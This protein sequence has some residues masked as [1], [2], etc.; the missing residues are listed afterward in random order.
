MSDVYGK[1]NLPLQARQDFLAAIFYPFFEQ[2]GAEITCIARKSSNAEHIPIKGTAYADLAS[3]KGL[4]GSLK[5][6]G[7]PDSHGCPCFWLRIPGLSCRER[8][9]RKANRACGR[10]LEKS[11]PCFKPG[12]SRA[13]RATLP[14]V[15]ETGRHF[16]ALFP[17]PTAGPLTMSES[18]LGNFF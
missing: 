14:G 18:I 10:D 1:K 15:G 2:A 13:V 11:C 17:L 7:Y 6:Q 4:Q 3:G 8:D 5:G 9:C 16:P 12:S